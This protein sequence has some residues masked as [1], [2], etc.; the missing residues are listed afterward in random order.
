M[1]SSP[2]TYPSGKKLTYGYDEA[3]HISSIKTGTVSVIGGVLYQPFASAAAQWVQSDGA[4]Y[5]LSYDLDGR[6]AGISIGGTAQA[7]ATN[8]VYSL[9]NNNYVIGQTETAQPAEGLSYDGLNRLTG[10]PSA[11]P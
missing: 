4:G 11:H 2:E 7:A 8:I 10:F 5:Q 1:A 6:I 3:G 9:D